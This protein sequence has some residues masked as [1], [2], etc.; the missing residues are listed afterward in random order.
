MGL[1]K[2]ADQAKLRETFSALTNDVRLVMFTQQFECQYCR[3]TR[4]LLQETAA[5]SER[6]SLEIF[7]FVAD[8]EQ[9]KL[10]GID[11]APAT[12][13]LGERDYGIRFYGV[14]SGYEFVTLIEDILDVGGRGHGLPPEVLTVLAKVDKPI[15]IEVLIS[16]TCPYCPK[17]VR[18][19]H[20]FAMANELIRGEM[21]ETSEFPYL[22]QR[23]NV[24]SVPHT[25]IN[26]KLSLVGALPEIEIAGKL[27][28]ALGG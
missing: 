13:V 25:V 6:I 15:R 12:V 26:E 7:D 10:Y 17:A 5:L 20:R 16:P 14:P 18:T 27:I 2:D 28:E 9:V 11:K 1:L 21:I 4:E 3:S 8:S 22:A 23:Y 24:Q 19:A